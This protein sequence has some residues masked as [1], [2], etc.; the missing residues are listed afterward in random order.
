MQDYL[1][2][3]YLPTRVCQTIFGPLF[4]ARFWS[5]VEMGRSD[6]I[7]Y[8]LFQKVLSFVASLF[9]FLNRK[10]VTCSLPS[11]LY[12]SARGPGIVDGPETGWPMDNR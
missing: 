5:F 12:P 3:G 9:S 8:S 7:G 10:Y 6:P 11:E 2:R 1:P 4:S